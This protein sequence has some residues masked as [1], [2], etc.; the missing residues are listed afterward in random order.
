MVEQLGKVNWGVTK[1]C[2]RKRSFWKACVT[3]CQN[4]G[5]HN[6]I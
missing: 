6:G 1:H 3:V 4:W 5:G 2:R